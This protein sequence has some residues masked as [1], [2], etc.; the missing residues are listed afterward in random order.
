LDVQGD[1]LP[2]ET[3]QAGGREREVTHARARLNT[4]SERPSVSFMV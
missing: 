4:P 2:F 3:D 1:D